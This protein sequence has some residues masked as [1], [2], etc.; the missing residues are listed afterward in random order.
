MNEQGRQDI[1]KKLVGPQFSLRDAALGILL[2]CLILSL[3]VQW[4]LL[5]FCVGFYAAGIIFGW[6]YSKG[7]IFAGSIASIL[8]LFAIIEGCR[9]I[10]PPWGDTM[11]ED[12]MSVPIASSYFATAI[13]FVSSPFLNRA[14]GFCLNEQIVVVAKLM[15]LTA[16]IAVPFIVLLTGV[17]RT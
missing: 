14:L 6:C 7:N 8:M 4:E 3:T 10:L 2:L 12:I 13:V 1:L 11:W 17:A 16:V 15:L 9:L 5:G